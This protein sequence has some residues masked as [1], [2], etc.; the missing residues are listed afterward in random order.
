LLGVWFFSIHSATAHAEWKYYGSDRNSN[1]VYYDKE[2]TTDYQG[3]VRIWRKKV[4]NPNIVRRTY[5]SLGIKYRNLKECIELLEIN[6]ISKQYQVKFHLYFDSNG[7]LIDKFD[8]KK[9]QGWRLIPSHTVI[10]R[11]YREECP[12]KAKK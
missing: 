3:I 9:G 8:Y 2:N 6:C 4:Y 5:E 10:Q 1:Y 11:F 7:T 12:Q